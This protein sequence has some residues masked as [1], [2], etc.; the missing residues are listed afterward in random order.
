MGE[1]ET[2]N[3]GKNDIERERMKSDERMRREVGWRGWR[4][5][6]RETKLY[7][8]KGEKLCYSVFG[9]V[10]WFFYLVYCEMVLL[11]FMLYLFGILDSLVKN[12][13]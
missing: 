1:K 7:V 2:I 12:I 10:L 6:K 13:L 8:N 9:W 11:F 5:R 3:I 4:K